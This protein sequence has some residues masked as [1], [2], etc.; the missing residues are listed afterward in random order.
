MTLI[1]KTVY[2]DWLGDIANEYNNA[3]HKTI[4]MKP[5][6]VKNNTY[7]DFGEES[8]NKDSNLKLVF[9]LELKKT[10]IFLLKVTLQ[11]GLEKFL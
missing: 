1:S 9:M 6:D 4:K 11:I 7:V 8:S 10:K 3:C 5:V 2:I